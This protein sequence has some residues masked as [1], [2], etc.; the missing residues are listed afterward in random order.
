MAAQFRE[1]GGDWHH[2]L[3]RDRGHSEEDGQ[4][5]K[6]LEEIPRWGAA[7]VGASGSRMVQ[8]AVTRSFCCWTSRM[9]PQLIPRVVRVA[10]IFLRAGVRQ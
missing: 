8:R 10:M 3:H 1:V 5:L 7:T 4:R 9:I 6:N 2:R